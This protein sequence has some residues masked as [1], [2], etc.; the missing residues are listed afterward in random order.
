MIFMESKQYFVYRGYRGSEPIAI[1]H[2]MDQVIALV[3]NTAAEHNFGFYRSWTMDG[4][5]FYDCGDIV[6]KVVEKDFQENA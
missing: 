6:Y 5:D 4:I 1:Y 3:H 2:N